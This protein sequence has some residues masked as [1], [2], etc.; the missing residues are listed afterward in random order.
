M[1]PADTTGLLVI[2]QHVTLTLPRS[3]AF[4]IA[5][6]T[7]GGVQWF[8]WGVRDMVERASVKVWK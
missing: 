6:L 3:A 1:T 4:L 8:W 7:F 2:A 5:L